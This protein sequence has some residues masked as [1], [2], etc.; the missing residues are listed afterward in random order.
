M[1]R[2]FID[3]VRVLN[4]AFLRPNFATYCTK[5]HLSLRY[6]LDSFNKTF[7]IIL[8]SDFLF[9]AEH[10]REFLAFFKFLFPSEESN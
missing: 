1:L 4:V 5:L 7:S 3:F 6:A 10:L 2:S 8:G 9:I